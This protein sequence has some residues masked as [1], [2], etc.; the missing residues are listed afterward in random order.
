MTFVLVGAD[1]CHQSAE[2]L[3]GNVSTEFVMNHLQPNPNPQLYATSR[4]KN[5]GLVG[6][7]ALATLAGVSVFE[8]VKQLVWP[9]IILWQSH[10]LTIVASTLVATAAAWWIWRKHIP[11]QQLVTQMAERCR[12]EQI[13]ADRTQEL[14]QALHESEEMY[15][16][17]VEASPDAIITSDLA[18]RITYVSKHTLDLYGATN[19]DDLLGKWAFEAITPE[20]HGRAAANFRQTLAEGVIRNAEYTLQRKDGSRYTGELSA[21]LLKGPTGRPKGFMAV[22]RDITER[23]Q[24]QQELERRLAELS[25]FNKITALINQTLT[26][27]K[28]LQQTIDEILDLPGVEEAIIHL[29]DPAARELMLVAYRGFSDEIIQIVNRINPARLE[30]WPLLQAGKPSLITPDS[31]TGPFK[32]YLEQAHIDAFVSLPL[33]GV[34]GLIG[35]MHLTISDPAYFNPAGLELLTSL[36][37]QLAIGL[38]KARLY[39]ETRAWAAE[40]EQRVE[41]RTTALAATE[42]RYQTLFDSALDALFVLDMQGYY[43]DAN[44]A[45]CQ[46]LGYSRDELLAMSIF[47][48][49]AN[50]IHAPVVEKTKI[51]K[52]RQAIWRQGMVGDKLQLVSKT[53]QVIEAE[54][55]LTPLTYNGQ[56]AV[57]SIVRDITPRVRAEQALRASENRYKIVSELTADYVFILKVKADGQVVMDLVTDNFFTATG[58]TLDEIKTPDSWNNVF[59]TTEDYNLALKFLQTV[60]T[61]KQSVELECRTL[62]KSNLLRWVHIFARPQWDEAEQR[63]VAVIGAVKDITARKQAEEALKDYSARLEEMVKE[64]TQ[65]LQTAQEQLLRREK[66]AVLGQLAGSVAHELRSPLGAVKNVAYLLK[67][68]VT[69]PDPGV[70]KN[71]QILER[72]VEKADRIINSLLDFARSKPPHYRLISINRVVQAALARVVIPPNITVTNHFDPI[73]PAIQADPEQ[74]EQVF[75]NLILNAVQAMSPPLAAGGQLTINSARFDPGW[76]MVSVADT[77]AGISP[78]HQTQLFEPLFTTKSKGIGLGLALVKMLVEGHQGVVEVESEGVPGQGSIF[79]VKLP[80][81]PMQKEASQ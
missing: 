11:N 63:V 1:K 58:R 31:Y 79:T 50:A 33:L 44:P 48:V 40:L 49:S 56:E 74:L 29:L 13:V 72:E 64:R 81:N 17:L 52:Q 55:S 38:E 53:G 5:I 60:I 22:V 41:A 61:S 57:L 80:V 69:E 4:L 54:V 25:V 36:G 43:L 66:L 6:L 42:A 26:V 47:S 21:A 68:G 14:H 19:P 70:H 67:T 7:T 77:G 32:A 45:A 78:E 71:A 15:R 59:P 39:A 51:L 62:V 65:A 34:S 23:K 8:L 37:Q 18:G 16:S 35:V 3:P 24:T 27:E 2:M 75:G 73:L 28:L 30:S 9:G 46:L 76:V 10:L 20:E 12:L